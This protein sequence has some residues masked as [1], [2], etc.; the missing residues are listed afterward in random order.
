MIFGRFLDRIEAKDLEYINS[1]AEAWLFFR[2]GKMDLIKYAITPITRNMG[3]KSIRKL[4][5]ELM[6]T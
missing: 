4:R 6:I 5:M 1:H 3:I 2:H